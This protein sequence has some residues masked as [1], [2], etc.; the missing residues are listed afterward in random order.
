LPHSAAWRWL[1]RLLA[2]NAPARTPAF[3]RKVLLSNIEKGFMLQKLKII[4]LLSKTARK[5]DSWQPFSNEIYNRLKSN[6][7]NKNLCFF[8]F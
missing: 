1:K 6:D 7:H 2:E 4:L 8:P 3:L 5:N